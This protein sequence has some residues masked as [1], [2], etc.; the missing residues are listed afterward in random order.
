MY[1]TS[2]IPREF[3][4]SVASVTLLSL[5]IAP[6]ALAGRQSASAQTTTV[7]PRFTIIP[8]D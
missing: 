6:A 1:S 2:A 8:L 7:I 5:R 4:F 3:T